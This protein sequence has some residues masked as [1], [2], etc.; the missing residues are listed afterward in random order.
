V[1]RNQIPCSL[2]ISVAD[3]VVSGVK[4]K[5]KARFHP[6][7]FFYL[8]RNLCRSS[9][10]QRYLAHLWDWKMDPSKG[11]YILTVHCAKL[12]CSSRQGEGQREIRSLLKQ[13]CVILIE[14]GFALMKLAPIRSK[15][16]DAT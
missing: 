11:K 8:K 12:T 10:P 9:L 2:E 13:F 15:G 1:G 3:A 14:K 6:P 7:N 5:Q 16:L 4:L